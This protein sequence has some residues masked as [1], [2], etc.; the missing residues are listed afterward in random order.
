MF[1]LPYS[2]MHAPLLKSVGLGSCANNGKTMAHYLNLP[3][4]RCTSHMQVTY[5]SHAGHMQVTCKLQASHMQVTCKL[6]A[7]HMQVTSKLQASH[8]QVTSKSHAS[9]MM[10][11]DL[12]VHLLLDVCRCELPSMSS[13]SLTLAS[14]LPALTKSSTPPTSSLF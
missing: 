11:C 12:V 1:A 2:N 13:Q 6:Q 7:S 14:G 3:E 4:V 10:A 8:M 9:H 5:K